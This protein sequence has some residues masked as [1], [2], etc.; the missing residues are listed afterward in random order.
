MRFIVLIA[1]ALA[2]SVRAEEV[3]SSQTLKVT[4]TADAGYRWPYYLF[5]PAEAVEA[6]QPTVLLVVPNNTGTASDDTKIH[7]LDARKRNAQSRR[8]AERLGVPLLVP[9]FPRPTADWKLYTHALDRD[10]LLTL[11]PKLKRL[12][13]QLLAMIDDAH[14]R[15][16]S[17]KVLVAHRILLRGHSASAMF[18]NR[19]ALLHPEQVLA[20]AAGSPGGWPMV[21]VG[22][23][24]AQVLRYPIGISDL[25]QVEGTAFNLA[26]FRRVHF[27]FQLGD[28]DTND[29]VPFADG[30]DP[31]DKALVFKLFGDAPVKR[32]PKAEALFRDAGCSCQFKLY[33][34]VDHTPS[35]EMDED[36]V[37]FFRHTLDDTRD[38]GY[39]G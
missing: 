20:V 27:L 19:F 37:N 38:G 2:S 1:V 39:S 26:A 28:K 15:L 35:D 31:E 17:R 13:R 3:V 29:S 12:D 24:K 4:P 30:Y 11:D 8:L 16:A 33:R 22:E 9:S 14:V 18:S 23:H 6:D 34:G 36:V 5:I 7:D 25:Q 10:T 32:W 21:P